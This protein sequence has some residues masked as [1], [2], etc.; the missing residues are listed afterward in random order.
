[1]QLGP[2]GQPIHR[3]EC[4]HSGPSNTPVHPISTPDSNAL[5]VFD[6]V[7]VSISL[8]TQPLDSSSSPVPPY[9][10]LN[11][12]VDIGLSIQCYA[13]FVGKFLCISKAGE[14]SRVRAQHG[15]G[16][17]LGNIASPRGNDHKPRLFHLRSF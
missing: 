11:Y 1:M 10:T 17:I 14:A 8:V 3:R 13:V 12:Q 16:R 2:S 4:R 5:R 6:P 15:W 9:P 7:A